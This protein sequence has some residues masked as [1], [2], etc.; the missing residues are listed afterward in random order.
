MTRIVLLVAVMG[1]VVRA[2][3]V[4]IDLGASR[5]ELVSA[6]VTPFPE[7]TLMRTAGGA[8]ESHTWTFDL[9]CSDRDASPSCVTP[10]EGMFRLR[11]GNAFPPGPPVA[12]TWLL[13]PDNASQYGY[14]KLISFSPFVD[15]WVTTDWAPLESAMLDMAQGV[16]DWSYL[17][18]ICLDCGDPKAEVTGSAL[19]IPAPPAGGRYQLTSIDRVEL[20][21]TDAVGYT[22][23]HSYYGHFVIVAEANVVPEPSGSFAFLLGLAGCFA[24]GRRGSIARQ[25]TIRRSRVA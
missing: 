3:T 22:L 2:D 15:E 5:A 23:T 17:A 10:L 1:S 7:F 16:G 21:Y 4:E 24:Y 9:Y 13:T 20:R 6:S 14:F 19:P 12:T 11:P 25:S 8:T 18:S